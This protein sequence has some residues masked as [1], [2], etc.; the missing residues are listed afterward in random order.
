M[1]ICSTIGYEKRHNEALSITDE[2]EFVQY[3]LARLGPQPPNFAKI[4]ALNFGQLLTTPAEP[5]A[6]YAAPGARA[7]RCRAHS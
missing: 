4:V 1:K 7:P 5:L 2:D 3:T 6:L